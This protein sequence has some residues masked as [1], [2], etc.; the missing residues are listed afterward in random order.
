M[1]THLMLQVLFKVIDK[2]C[3][4]E[5]LSLLARITEW[6]TDLSI[7]DRRVL[8]TII[9]LLELEVPL[10]LQSLEEFLDLVL[11]MLA[12]LMPQWVGVSW[13]LGGHGLLG[14]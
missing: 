5:D 4:H 8:A 9:V 7:V 6:A 3:H 14:Q 12:D 11:G 10:G 13:K 2:R 1:I